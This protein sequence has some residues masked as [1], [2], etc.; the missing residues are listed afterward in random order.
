MNSNE[1]LKK[2]F[3]LQKPR[4]CFAH[5]CCSKTKAKARFFLFARVAKGEKNE[6]KNRRTSSTSSLP[7]FCFLFYKRFC[8]QKKTICLLGA[9]F[10]GKWKKENKKKLSHFCLLVKKK[11][12]VLGFFCSLTSFERKIKTKHAFCCFFAGFA[13]LSKQEKKVFLKFFFVCFIEQF[14]F[15]KQDL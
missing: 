8:S 3:Q 14:D 13:L 5:F 7:G 4:V 1:G 11:E 6:Q 2:L 10:S 12:Q 9:L 15:K